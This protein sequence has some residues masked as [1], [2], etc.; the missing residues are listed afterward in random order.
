MGGAPDLRRRCHFGR[1]Q[2]HSQEGLSGRRR[3]CPGRRDGQEPDAWNYRARI[4]AGQNLFDGR[5]N[6]MLVAEFTKSDGLIG[7]PERNLADDYLFEPPATPPPAGQCCASVSDPGLHGAVDDPSA[8]C[9]WWTIFFSAPAS[10]S[11]A[12]LVGVTNAAGQTWRLVRA[13]HCCPTT[14]GAVNRQSRSS[15]AAATACGFRRS[16]N[17]LSPTERINVDTLTTFRSTIISM[18]SAKASFP[19][20]MRTNLISQPTY[21]TQPVRRRRHGRRQFRRQHQQSVPEPGRSRH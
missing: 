6:V 5:M 2:H 11:P 13:A 7:T 20:P 18:S 3:R 10:V 15:T 1:G 21:N 8:A 4:L 17:L 19:R 12:A 9:R 16:A 14:S